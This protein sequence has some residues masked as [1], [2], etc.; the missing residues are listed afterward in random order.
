VSETTYVN[1]AA[2]K[3]AIL[4]ARTLPLSPSRGKGKRRTRAHYALLT[5]I[6]IAG[7]INHDSGETWLA[8]DTIAK[9]T[10]GTVS[11]AKRAVSLLVDSGHLAKIQGGKGK[12]DSNTYR[13]G[14]AIATTD[15]ASGQKIENELDDI[16]PATPPPTKPTASEAAIQLAG[17]FTELLAQPNKHSSVRRK[18]WPAVFDRLLLDNSHA[19]LLATLEWVFTVD[20]FWPPLIRATSGDPAEYL[21]Q[22]IDTI[23]AAKAHPVSQTLTRVATPNRN[24]PAPPSNAAAL[25]A[26]YAL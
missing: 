1:Y 8:Y 2:T 6:I 19:D 15:T 10:L 3:L 7:H 17:R 24:A 13:L 18:Q 14:P 22:K 20:A 16:I 11:S 9:E 4:A 21:T 5:L 23:I 12:R 26:P 25:L